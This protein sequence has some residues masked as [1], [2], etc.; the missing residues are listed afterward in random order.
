LAA[1]TGESDAPDLLARAAR[2]EPDAPEPRVA[3][4]E[5]WTSRDPDRARPE[6]ER[7]LADAP[8]HAPALAALAS[9]DAQA[10]DRDAARALY[11]RAAVEAPA[12]FSP[13]HN[14]AVLEER[15]GHPGEAEHWYRAA[16]RASPRAWP[17]HYNLG[18]GLLERGEVE[19]AAVHLRAAESGGVRLAPEIAARLT[20]SD[21]P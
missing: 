15:D 9:L 16:I 2:A 18:L 4:A 1:R 7:V 20:N 10:G 13:R 5:W 3:L 6:L 8:D 21:L 14:L 12:W 11:R 17:S 19:E